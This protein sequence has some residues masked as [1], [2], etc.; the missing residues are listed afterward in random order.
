LLLFFSLDRHVNKAFAIAPLLIV[1]FTVE[2]HIIVAIDFSMDLSFLILIVTYFIN[3]FN[4][5]LLYIFNY[6]AKGK[7]D[8]KR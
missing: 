5:V 1:L 2:A 4:P 6:T 8:Y 3:Y 7:L